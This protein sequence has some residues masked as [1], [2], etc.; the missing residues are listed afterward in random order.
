MISC[1]TPLTTPIFGTPSW[2]SHSQDNNPCASNDNVQPH[3]VAPPRATT[4]WLTTTITRT[5]NRCL[6]IDQSR[7]L[8]GV[9]TSIWQ[10]PTLAQP[11]F[12]LVLMCTL[13]NLKDNPLLQTQS[14]T[15]PSLVHFCT[16]RSALI[17]ISPLLCP[18][19]HSMHPTLC[20]SI[21]DL[22]SISWPTLWALW[23]LS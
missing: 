18:I 9:L 12:P 11:H 5:T 6:E 8:W 19:W 23:M 4:T 14:C 21:C 20:L 1:G 2:P 3:E 13:S 22:Q 7:Y 17:L 10:M 16:Y 15:S